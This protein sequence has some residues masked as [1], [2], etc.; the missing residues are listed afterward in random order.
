[1]IQAPGPTGQVIFAVCKLWLLVFPAAW[2]LL[3][4]RGRPSWSPPLLGGLGVGAVSGVAMGA[5]MVAGYWLFASPLISRSDLRAVVESIDLD[6][7]AAF[8]AGAIY[9]VLVNSLVE[10]YVYRWFVLRQCRALMPGAAAVLAA[11]A[12]FTAHHV[13][14]LSVYLDAGLTALGSIGVFAGGALWS[15]LYLRYRSVWPCWISHVL[16]DI[17]VFAIGWRI[18]FME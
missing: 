16:V 12:V 13:V 15:W 6:S 8:F 10:E 2:Y 7:P 9:W 1:M 18:V 14:A 4:E 3:V 11:A 5:A 17:A